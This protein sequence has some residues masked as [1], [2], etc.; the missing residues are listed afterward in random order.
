MS[1][2]FPLWDATIPHST[3]D[4]DVPNRMTRFSAPGSEL[5][6][7]VVVLPGGGYVGRTAHE[8]VPIAEFYQ[9]QGFHAFVVDYRIAPHRFPAALS[10]VQRA[11]RLIRRNAADW[12]VDPQRIFVCGFSAGGHLAA[13]AAILADDVS[14]VGDAADAFDFRPNGAVLGYPVISGMEAHGHTGSHQNLL[15]ERFA[16]E[17]EPLSL[18]NRVDSHTPPCFIWH[19]AADAVV[20]VVHSLVLAEALAKQKIPYELHIFP[21]GYHGL[22]LALDDPAY[23]DVARWA[24]WSADWIRRI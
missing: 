13:S 18:Q 8:G 12:C 7:A 16:A 10:D 21:H 1:E 14:A 23:A 17:C 9:S 6:P 3:P 15:G 19:T 11:I 24:G 4:A 2:N 20:P 22:G 5:K